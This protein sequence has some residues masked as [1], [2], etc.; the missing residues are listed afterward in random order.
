MLHKPFG[1]T[2]FKRIATFILYF[3]FQMHFGTYLSGH[4]NSKIK[5]STHNN[6]SDIN[7]GMFGDISSSDVPHTFFILILAKDVLILR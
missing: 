3:V 1:N 7:L 2:H 6:Q 4:S 5:H